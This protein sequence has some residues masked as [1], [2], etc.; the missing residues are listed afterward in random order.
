[1][2]QKH[3]PAKY[4]VAYGFSVEA[5]ASFP[6]SSLD[7]FADKPPSG[8]VLD[9]EA[10]FS[11][12]SFEALALGPHAANANADAAMIRTL[13]KLLMSRFSG[14]RRFFSLQNL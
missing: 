12:A 11:A 10:P 7:C 6:P 14:F 8:W 4:A 5:E 13:Q 2:H 3:P 1:M 9:V